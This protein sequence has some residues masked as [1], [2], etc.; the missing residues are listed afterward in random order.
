VGPN[1]RGESALRHSLRGQGGASLV[2]RCRGADLLAPSQQLAI[3]PRLGFDVGTLLFASSRDVFDELQLT[4]YANHLRMRGN[5]ALSGEQV[6]GAD[7]VQDDLA[8]T[9]IA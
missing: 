6:R 9:A 1:D 4:S 7:E 3:H 8:E 5:D 2:E